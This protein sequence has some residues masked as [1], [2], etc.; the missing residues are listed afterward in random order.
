M[1]TSIL[2]PSNIDETSVTFEVRKPAMV[3]S[4]RLEQP[5]NMEHIFVTSPVWNLPASMACS[6][7]HPLNMKLMSVTFL[8]L[9]FSRPS[10]AVRLLKPSNQRAVEAGESLN[11]GSKMTFVK[12][13]R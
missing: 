9:K 12:R 8:V 6:L 4:T 3:R 5:A 11:D 7:L 1:A 2:Q 13:V 10:I